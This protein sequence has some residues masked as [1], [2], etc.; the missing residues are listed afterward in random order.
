MEL[1]IIIPTFNRLRILKE[2]LEA[3]EQCQSPEDGYEVIVV[4]DG[5]SDG[6]NE[7]LREWTPRYPFH[8][9]EQAHS[10]PSAA[11]NLGVQ[12]AVS[13]RLLFLGDDIIPDRELLVAHAKRAKEYDNSDDIAV[14]GYVTWDARMRLTPFLSH[15][16]EYGL[17]FGYSLISNY[18]DVPYNF[19]YTS[20]ISVSKSRFIELGGFDREF[21]SAM[22]EDIE[23]GYRFKQAGMR[24][25]YEPRAQARHYH[26]MG[27]RQFAKR[28]KNSGQKA[29]VFARKHPELA[30]ELGVAGL[31]E[32]SGRFP[33]VGLFR[34]ELSN[35]LPALFSPG[36]CDKVM[37]QVFLA[38]ARAALSNGEG[39][40]C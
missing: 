32:R 30:K 40:D 29:V 25:V 24:I 1:S 39:R 4:S 31:N 17:Q 26:P 36:L 10:G 19:F 16:N 18:E 15:I 37:W 3:L 28:R 14:L 5:S 20:N 2:V 9:I 12:S 7:W 11:R 38:G 27:P 33:Y 23:F 21:S 35:Y 34:L 6:T 22:W 13:N 8:F